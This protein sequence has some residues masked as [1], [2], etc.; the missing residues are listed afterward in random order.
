MYKKMSSYN[1]KEY[2]FLISLSKSSKST[3]ANISLIV[4]AFEEMEDRDEL[5]VT[6]SDQ[7]GNKQKL[8]MEVKI[9][10]LNEKA[11]KIDTTKGK[12]EN[13]EGKEKGYIKTPEKKEVQLK[14][15][16]QR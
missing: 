6:V 15:G 10:E 5:A 11:K 13:F 16:G 4:E 3:V 14:K 9:L 1:D 12:K 8:R 7:K 2:K